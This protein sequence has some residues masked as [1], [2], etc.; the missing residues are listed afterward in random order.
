MARLLEVYV[1]AVNVDWVWSRA[2]FRALRRWLNV[3]DCESLA[4]GIFKSRS[5][6]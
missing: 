5:T 3:M 4:T 1:I 6:Y 2:A